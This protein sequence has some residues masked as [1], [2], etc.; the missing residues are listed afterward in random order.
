MGP[1]LE[2]PPGLQ[3][4]NHVQEMVEARCYVCV[5]SVLQ[6]NSPRGVQVFDHKVTE[7][8]QAFYFN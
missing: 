5:H 7:N 6:C 8:I 3:Q 4:E 1:S 2:N